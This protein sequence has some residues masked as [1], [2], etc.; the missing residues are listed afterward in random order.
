MLLL[1]LIYLGELAA[2]AIGGVPGTDLDLVARDGFT[3]VIMVLFL[4]LAVQVG[5]GQPVGV[6]DTHVMPRQRPQ[7]VLQEVVPTE[8]GQRD[9]KVVEVHLW[10]TK[11]K[12]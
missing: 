7:T 6:G 11:R 3:E 2:E 8:L 12:I 4:L 1:L 9:A 10:P 5:D